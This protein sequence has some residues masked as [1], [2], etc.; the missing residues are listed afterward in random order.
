VLQWLL[1]NQQQALQVVQQLQAINPQRLE[2]V[3]P[4]G[5]RMRIQAQAG[6]PQLRLKTKR[7]NGWLEV[8]GEVQVDEDRV[9]QLRQLLEALANQPGQYLRLSEQDW[10]ALSDS[11]K[12]G[13]SNWPGWPIMRWLTACASAC[14]PP[15]CWPG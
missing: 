1:A 8:T 7:K 6:L 15:R 14:W 9:L 5:Q 10:L 4:Q 13:C 12:P 3:W 2:C 11:C